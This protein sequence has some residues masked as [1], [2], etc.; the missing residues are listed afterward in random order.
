MFPGSNLFFSGVYFLFGIFEFLLCFCEFLIRF[1]LFFFILILSLFYFLFSLVLYFS[2]SNLTAAVGNILNLFFCFFYDIIIVVRI[3]S[4]PC[5]PFHSDIQIRADIQFKIFF[6][7]HSKTAD[8]PISYSCRSP[9][10][11][12]IIGGTSHSDYFQ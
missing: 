9:V 6:R 12:K 8:L 1:F 10:S 5:R 4:L 11:G 2:L 3:C 7:H